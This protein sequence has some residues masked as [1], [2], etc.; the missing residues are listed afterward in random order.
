MDAE[1]T[2][3]AVPPASAPREDPRRL[4]WRTRKPRKFVLGLLIV[5]VLIGVVVI[6]INVNLAV[7]PEVQGPVTCSGTVMG[8]TDSCQQQNYVNGEPTT[9][10]YF[11]YDQM[12]DQ[13][14]PDPYAWVISLSIGVV[15]TGLSTWGI[16]RWFR[17]RERS[18]AVH[19]L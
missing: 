4:A 15:W 2:E 5:S 1:S 16:V 8:T 19:R 6:G 13:Q 12:R 17:Q 9:T 10:Q 3:D 14:R 11:T 18:L 7:D